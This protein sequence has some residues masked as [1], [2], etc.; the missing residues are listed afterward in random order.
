MDPSPADDRGTGVYLRD[1]TTGITTLVSLHSDDVTVANGF[2]TDASISGDGTHVAFTTTASNLDPADAGTAGQRRLRS[3]PDAGTTRLASRADGR[4]RCGRQRQL[5]LPGARSGRLAG[6][7]RQRRYEPRR[8]RDDV[9]ARASTGATSTT[10]GTALVSRD[11]ANPDAA[12]DGTEPS[13]NADGTLV[14]F[15]SETALHADDNN[16]FDDVYRRDIPSGTTELVSRTTADAGQHLRCRH[17]VDQ[18]RRRRGRVQLGQPARR[19][20]RHQQHA[21]RLRPRA[22]SSS[23]RRR[24]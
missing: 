5:P 23:R 9:P 16:A 24:S 7:V 19:R 22:A 11:N 2:A 6:G 4:R 21:R 13:I 1:L 8:R 3:R 18:R 17:A 14:A 12:A 15:T 10:D 20:R